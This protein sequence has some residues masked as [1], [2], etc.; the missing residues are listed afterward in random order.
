MKYRI[1]FTVNEHEDSID[2]EGESVEDIRGQWDEYAQD[3]PVKDM[4]SESL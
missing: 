1:H 4:W 2:L 3:K